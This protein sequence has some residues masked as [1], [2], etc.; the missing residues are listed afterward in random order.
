LAAT[1]DHHGHDAA[2]VDFLEA[3]RVEDGLS[4][5]TVAAYRADLAAFLAWLGP[6]PLAEF[7]PEQV[8]AWLAHL[9]AAGAKETGVARKF[10]SLR[11]FVRFL[12]AEGRLRRDATALFDAPRL[13]KPLPKALSRTEVE[14]LLECSH[15]QDDPARHARDR[16]LLEA[17]YACGG[18]VAEVVGLALDDLDPQFALARLHG[19]GRKTRVVPL[20]APAREALRAWI[21]G[22][23]RELPGAARQPRIFLST[24]G[25]PL[26][27]LAAWR[28]VRA[29]ALA[30]G[31]ARAVSPHALRHSFATHLVE[32][33]ADLRSVQ[34]LLGHASIRTTEVYTR[35]DGDA[36]LALHRARHPRA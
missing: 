19:K 16:A 24:R 11:R 12:V 13:G 8:V 7:E 26:S 5:S 18:R 27:R 14:R 23:R 1:N 31:I 3:V 36:L 29:S 21:E 10:S 20:G 30:A 2:L 4:R 35:L 22:A 32:G 17:L 34:E 6:R 33:G 25:R 28:I 9:R 15:A